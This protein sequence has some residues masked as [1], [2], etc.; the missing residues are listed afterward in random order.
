MNWTSLTDLFSGIQDNNVHFTSLLPLERAIDSISAEWKV[1]HT[2]DDRQAWLDGI[3]DPVWSSM[4][5]DIS[6]DAALE[7]DRETQTED[8]QSG[9]EV[10][11]ALGVT[12][13]PRCPL[14]RIPRPANQGSDHEM[15]FP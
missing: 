5:K 8:V 9:A 13:S 1:E 2:A 3:L 12:V 6:G 15:M 11:K 7:M 10:T 14:V 4:R